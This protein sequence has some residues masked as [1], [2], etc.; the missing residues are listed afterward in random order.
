FGAEVVGADV[1]RLVEFANGL[2]GTTRYI[3]LGDYCNS[4]GAADMGLLPDRLPGYGLIGDDAVRKRWEQLWKGRLPTTPGLNAR[5]MF[6]SGKL[7]A[8]YVVGSNPVKT[9]GLAA[10]REA[11]GAPDLLVVHEL[12]LTETAALVDVVL[13]AAC[14]Y[15]KEGTFTNTCGELQRVKR[16]LE[17]VGLRTD[18]E[19]LRL[20][21]YALGRPIPLRTPEAALDEI[22][23][24]VPG[25]QVSLASVLA[26]EAARTAPV[27]GR[28]SVDTPAGLIVSADDSLFTSGSLTRYSPALNSVPER[29]LPR[30]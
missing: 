12:F 17:P 16:A 4:R 9:Y 24:H 20:L 3:A 26:G 19:I 10:K 27:D 28:G 18:F 5:E 8:L 14:A 6:T 2:P 7:R 11:L 22:R 1:V 30:S 25:Y 21:S 23:Q 29:N 15:E 13:P